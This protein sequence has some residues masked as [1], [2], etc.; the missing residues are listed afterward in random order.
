MGIND[1]AQV[2]ED[3]KT[4]GEEVAKA[5]ESDPNATLLRGLKKLYERLAITG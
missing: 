4:A 5:E 3:I 2:L 1:P